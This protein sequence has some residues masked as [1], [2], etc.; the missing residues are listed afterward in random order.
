MT[1]SPS[2]PLGFILGDTLVRFPSASGHGV[3][4]TRHVSFRA[5][6]KHHL[7][8]TTHLRL[9]NHPAVYDQIRFWLEPT[10]AAL[11]TLGEAES[12]G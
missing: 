8:M 11:T 5:V 6:N 10:T 4:P 12:T 1:E 9:L 7:G 2:D 3:Q